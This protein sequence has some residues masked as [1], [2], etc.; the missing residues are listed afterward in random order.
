MET[1]IKQYRASRGLSQAA[2]AREVGKSRST[3][4]MYEGGTVEIPAGVL[5]RI[6]KVL[7]VPIGKLIRADTDPPSDG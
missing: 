4:A 2:L 6:S 5:Y 7:K 3:I 1:A